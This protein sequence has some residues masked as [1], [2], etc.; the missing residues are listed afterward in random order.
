MVSGDQQKFLYQKHKNT[1]SKMAAAT[2]SKSAK[3]ALKI[4][5]S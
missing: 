3:I 1:K 4:P 5:P 2:I